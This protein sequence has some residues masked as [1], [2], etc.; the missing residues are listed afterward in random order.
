MEVFKVIIHTHGGNEY[1][2]NAVSY[3]IDGRQVLERGY[4]VNPNDKNVAVMQLRKTAEY[5][6]NQGKSPLFHYVTSYSSETAPTPEKAMEL[7]GEIFSEITA[8]HQALIGIHNEERGGSLHHAHTLVSPTDYRTGKMIYADNSTNYAMAQRMADV[9]GQP[10]KLVV[11]KED[12][13]EWECPIVFTP[14]EE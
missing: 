14:R 4:G 13:T 11:R 8:S 7:T 2:R 3:V 6:R 1:I 12:E 5:F 10:T 9:T